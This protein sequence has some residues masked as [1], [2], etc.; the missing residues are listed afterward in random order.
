MSIWLRNAI[1]KPHP[2][3]GRRLCARLSLIFLVLCIDI[4]MLFS[5]CL[6]IHCVRSIY[7]HIPCVYSYS[8]WLYM[9]LHYCRVAGSHAP[10]LCVRLLLQF[11]VLVLFLW[12]LYEWMIDSCL[13]SL[14]AACALCA[15]TLYAMHVCAYDNSV[16]AFMYEKVRLWAIIYCFSRIIDFSP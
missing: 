2:M 16:S 9:Y 8:V 14:R 1:M 4:D 5:V 11:V 3:Q 10:V 15:C 12:R 6:F 7:T 13:N